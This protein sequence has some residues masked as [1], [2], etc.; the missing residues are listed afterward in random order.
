MLSELTMFLVRVGLFSCGFFIHMASVE[1]G[2]IE[3]A[4]GCPEIKLGIK[5]LQDVLSKALSYS[6]GYNH[7]FPENA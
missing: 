4:C 7:F 3:V 5:C 1:G 6:S 2:V